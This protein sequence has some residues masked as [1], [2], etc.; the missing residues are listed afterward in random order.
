[1]PPFVASNQTDPFLYENEM[2][3]HLLNV[4]EFSDELKRRYKEFFKEPAQQFAACGV[5]FY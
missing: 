3:E 1:L 2:Y 5:R 4:D